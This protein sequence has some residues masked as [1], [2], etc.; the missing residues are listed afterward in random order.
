MP[1]PCL[2]R[3]LLILALLMSVGAP[4]FAAVPV[5]S[6]EL[7][8]NEAF[9]LAS[10]H[11]PKAEKAL[12]ALLAEKP[13]DGSVLFALGRLALYESDPLKPG[14]KRKKLRLQARDYMARAQAA[15]YSDPFIDS[16]LAAIN[17]DGSENKPTFSD[18]AKV[19]KLMQEGETFFTRREFAKAA[20][21]YQAALAL[22][23]DNYNAALFVGD[24][25]FAANELE[26]AITWFD[27]ARKLDP[28]RETAHRY[29]G[30]AYLRLRRP[31]EAMDCYLAAVVAEPY[32]GYPW[33]TLHQ[34]CQAALIK[35]WTAPRTLPT[36]EIT[37]AE[38][39]S[40]LGL[41]QDFTVFDIAYGT[42]RMQWQEENRAKRF[43]GDKQYR[44]T[45]EEETYALRTTIQVYREMKS[46]PD[47]ADGLAKNLEQ[48]RMFLDHLV[49]ID[50]AGL[51]EAHALLARG[52]ADLAEDYAAYRAEHRQQAYDYLHRFYLHQQ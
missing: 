31:A 25:H 19:E 51:L 41:P 6:Y 20:A 39:K 11:S 12:K 35:A 14:S 18:Q 33:R 8:R 34:F 22:E 3:L 10:T 21:K 17:P 23:P 46:A 49:A 9:Q 4:A 26:D 27:R 7:R 44:Q 48:L 47:E 2:T 40:T 29:A 24:C 38:G 16:N 28:D 37:Q 1:R 5:N 30:D 13:D 15:G 50:D 52:N 43:P 42:A 36:A 32:N 45:L